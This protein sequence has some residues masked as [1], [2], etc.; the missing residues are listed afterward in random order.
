MSPIYHLLCAWLFLHIWFSSIWLQFASLHWVCVIRLRWDFYVY[1]MLSFATFGKFLPLFLEIL[2]VSMSLIFYSVTVKAWILELFW[3]VGGWAER[4][5]DVIL[6]ST[7]RLL[8]DRVSPWPRVYQLCWTS[9]ARESQ[10]SSCLGHPVLDLQMHAAGLI[11]FVWVFCGWP[12][13][14]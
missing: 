14:S 3:G 2:V 11:L 6:R 13:S 4:S 5:S 12:S 1:K 9:L 10:R 7:A 8:W